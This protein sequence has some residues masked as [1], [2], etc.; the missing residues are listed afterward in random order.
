MI[1]QTKNKKLNLSSHHRKS[2]LRNQAIQFIKY[3]FL[4]TTLVSAKEVRRLVEKVVTIA[5]KG[6]D[7]NNRRR[8]KAILPYDEKVLIKLFLEIAPKYVSRPGGY[9]SV[10]RLGTRISDTAQIGRLMWV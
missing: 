8:V 7:F 1:H 6:N 10:Y 4:E 5:R 9:T 2:Y 3:G